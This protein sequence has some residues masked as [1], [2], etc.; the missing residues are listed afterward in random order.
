MGGSRLAARGLGARLRAA[1]AA[2][3]QQ[4]RAAGDLPVKTNKW[5]E[6]HGAA[7]ENVEQTF[8]W[9]RRSIAN[10]VIFAGAWT[11]AARAAAARQS[12]RALPNPSCRPPKPAPI[13]LHLTLHRPHLLSPQA[14]S[15]TASSST[16]LPSLS[17]PTRRRG[18]R[19]ATWS[20]APRRRS[21]L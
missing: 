4:R 12:A 3:L 14:S 7:R 17:A 15:P 6:E 11:R 9:T 10:L 21:S 8:R 18:A 16:A 13:R 1:A 19:G 20:A 2:Q 5:V